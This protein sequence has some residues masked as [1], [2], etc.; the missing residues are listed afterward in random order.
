M[1]ANKIVALSILT[2]ALTAGVASADHHHGGW[3]GRG[4]WGGRGGWHTGVGARYQAPRMVVAPRV[5]MHQPHG[6]YMSPG[7][8]R[9]P[10][11][12]AAPRIRVHYY[13]YYA[14]PTVL[15]ENYAPMTGYYWVAGQWSWNGYEWIWAAGHYEPDPNYVAPGYS[16]PSYGYG[17]DYD[18][19][20]DCDQ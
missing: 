11:Y 17:Y 13:D 4:S 9:R 1:T 10:I 2:L 19:D 5:Y 15:A 14:P 6:V 20:C 8:V 3:G 16:D 18:Y 7:F 12:V